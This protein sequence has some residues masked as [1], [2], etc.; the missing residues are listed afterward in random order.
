M[1]SKLLEFNLRI[2]RRKKQHKG[3]DEPNW[4]TL[5]IYMETSQQK[6]L[7]NY[8]MLIKSL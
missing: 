7:Y 4:G 6:P 1:T 8:Y 2:G 3:G 5:H